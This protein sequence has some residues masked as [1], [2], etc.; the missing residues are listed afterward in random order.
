MTDGSDITDAGDAA[1]GNGD[2]GESDELTSMTFE[3][4][5]VVLGTL[6]ADI[7][8]DVLIPGVT[9]PAGG[10]AT[11][12]AGNGGFFDLLTGGTYGL[13]L[14]VDSFDIFYTGGEIAI[15]GNGFATEAF[16][17][18]PF[19]PGIVPGT[20]VLISFS[21]QVDVLTDNG[22]NVQTVASSGT[23][24]VRGPAVPEPGTLLLSLLGGLV[25]CMMALRYRWG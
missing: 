25:G 16:N 6:T 22:D 20:E 17:D 24:E 11:T 15:F 21:T 23:G 3:L 19:G 5:D 2:P 10:G 8:A 13:K 1:G 12:S 4:D 9:I 14:G 18:L 7:H